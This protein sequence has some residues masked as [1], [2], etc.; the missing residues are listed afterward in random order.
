MGVSLVS[1]ANG[2]ETKAVPQDD[3]TQDCM[4]INGLVQLQ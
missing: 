1:V 2:T 3:V 4:A